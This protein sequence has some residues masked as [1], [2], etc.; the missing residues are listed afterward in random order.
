[1]VIRAAAYLRIS[2][3]DEGKGLG[4]DRQ[5]AAVQ[6]LCADKGWELD[7]RWVIEE[8]NR[9]AWDDSKPRPGFRRLLRGMESGEVQAVAVYAFDRLARRLRDTA[10]VLDLVEKQGVQVATVTG[11]LDLSSS[12]GRGIA[13]MLG[14]LAA[15]EMASMTE[16][17]RAKAEQNVQAGRVHNG[18]TRPYGYE[19]DRKTPRPD[20]VAVLREMA[21]HV[22]RGLS[23]TSLAR[24]LNARGV[25]TTGGR[26]WDTRK[27]K[28]V[29]DNPRL[30]GRVVHRG[31][32][33][34]GVR[35]EWEPVLTEATFDRLQIAL[36]A[37]RVVQ[38]RWTNSRRHLLSGSM[39]RCGTCNE[40]V[41][42]FQQST[43]VWAYRCRGH[44]TRNEAH[45]DRHVREATIAY[46]LE[47]PVRIEAWDSE[48]QADL[49]AQVVALEQRKAEAVRAFAEHGGDAAAL[50]M[51]TADLRARIDAA[52]DRQIER[53]VL[54]TGLDWAQFDVSEVLNKPAETPEAIDQQRA[55]LALYVERVVLHPSKK[56]GRGYDE[57]ATDVVFRDP[58][59]LTW[60]G[61][62]ERS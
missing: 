41:V 52:K 34:P 39:L 14:S 13:G 53:A 12:Y 15:M 55:V 35:G 23:L 24:S 22:L 18:G 1:M 46:A 42:A 54:E 5:L 3:D 57:T 50:A 51:L 29:L 20:E 27:V 44:V 21:D 56:R 8:N 17:L 11:G 25:T 60:R 28:D 6:T 33:V 9:F 45:V 49:H 7:P 36:A 16:R 40:K 61:V 37:R 59:R 19:L 26:R 48:E 30:C 2:K 38:E 10:A 62:I 47:H 31:Q 4:I 58:N 32:V 43:G